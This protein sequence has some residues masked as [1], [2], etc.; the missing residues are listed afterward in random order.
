MEIRAYPLEILI[1][2]T[3]SEHDGSTEQKPLIEA[4]S[5]I[6]RTSP[7]DETS[8]AYCLHGAGLVAT[9]SELTSLAERRQSRVFGISMGLWRPSVRIQRTNR[10]FERMYPWLRI[11]E[12]RR[13]TQIE[14]EKV[15]SS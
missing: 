13:P 15:R 4:F 8:H 9:P 5:E 11:S 6:D 2:C 14:R 12:R 10:R 3:K 1:L 7:V